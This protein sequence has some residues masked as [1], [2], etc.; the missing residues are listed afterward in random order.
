M[1][2][3]TFGLLFLAYL[4][5]DKL[6][7]KIKFIL[8]CL[9]F[10]VII[11]T[12]YGLGPDYFAYYDIYDKLL[13]DSFSDLMRYYQRIDF[14]YRLLIW[15]FRLLDIPFHVFFAI[16]NSVVFLFIYKW[17][18][19][20]SDEPELSLLLF[21]SMFFFVWVMSAARQ[22]IVLTFGLYFLFSEKKSLNFKQSVILILFLSLFHT[23]A[24]FLLV[25]LILKKV[26]WIRKHHL[27]FMGSTI[28]L[29]HLPIAKILLKISFIPNISRILTNYLSASPQLFDFPG[30]V[31]IAIFIVL[32][33]FYDKLK[34]KKSY[35]D[36]VMYGFSIY[37]LLGFS[38]LTASRATIYTFFLVIL[39]I[40]EILKQLKFQAVLVPIIAFTGTFVYFNKEFNTMFNQSAYLHDVSW[41]TYPTIFDSNFDDFAKKGSYE[42]AYRLLLKDHKAL[43][44]NSNDE[45]THNDYDINMNYTVVKNGDKYGL[46]DQNGDWYLEP[47]YSTNIELI[48]HILVS[49]YY[50]PNNFFS[51]PQLEDLSGQDRTQE[52]MIEIVKAYKG[53]VFFESNYERAY[54]VA[55]P[56]IIPEKIRS[57]Y[58][59]AEDI[60]QVLYTR[61]R[62]P[63]MYYIVRID[64]F[65]DRSYIYLDSNFELL[66]DVPT[67]M[68]RTF[69]QEGF[70]HV[71]TKQGDIVVNQN[72][73]II[74]WE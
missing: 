2:Y 23:S 61:I 17:I 21:Y 20:N 12:R 25:Y 66:I 15:P 24:L 36:A 18:W 70:L 64:Y 9:P 16:S 43:S 31:R 71:G 42:V 19:D 56:D 68:G 73:D 53:E 27:I 59:S 4:L 5:R 26:N 3:I 22:S 48:D 40:P 65:G 58:P 38:E 37:F 10:L 32:I 55:E 54:G 51:S 28:L 14:G 1:L 11:W 7:K 41:H 62:E 34:H 13:V 57:L 49:Y 52:E 30:L 74:W 8:L 69:S 33:I 44:L 60:S 6:N 35:V 39:L 50:R 63:F 67:Y 45:K 47:N 46:M 72:G 29:S